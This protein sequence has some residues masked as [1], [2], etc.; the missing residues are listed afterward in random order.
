MAV[1]TLA[2]GSRQIVHIPPREA[3]HEVASAFEVDKT[4]RIQ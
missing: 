3:P 4:I 1:L 2:V